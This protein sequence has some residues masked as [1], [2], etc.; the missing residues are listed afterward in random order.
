MPDAYTVYNTLTTRFGVAGRNRIEDAYQFN[1]ITTADLDEMR[2]WGMTCIRVP[3]WYLTV[4]ETNGAWRSDAFTHLDWIVNE[5]WKRGIYTI[6]DFHGLPGGDCPWAS[7]GEVQSSGQFF[8][9]YSDQVEGASIWYNIAAHFNGNP[10]IAAYDLLNEPN[11]SPNSGALWNIYNWY[12]YTMSGAP[13]PNHTIQLEG[14]WDWSTLPNPSSYGW[15]NVA[16][17][18]HAYAFGANG[19]YDP[20]TA[21]VDGAA[22]GAI[23][24]F[25]NYQSCNIPDYLE[26]SSP[27]NSD[28]NSFLYEHAVFNAYGVGWANWTWKAE[29]GVGDN[30]ADTVP[31]N[32]PSVPNSQKDGFDA[33]HPRRLHNH[34]DPRPLRSESVA[35][36]HDGRTLRGGGHLHLD[37]RSKLVCHRQLGCI[38]QR[39]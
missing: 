17:H 12:F 33:D 38:V 32:W 31:Y 6:L 11:S 25:L 10:G 35:P 23:S 28:T 29:G 4:V 2:S 19:T 8:N 5:A 37:R 14:N 22:W 36:K 30:W 7:C 16:Y 15:S 18:Q 27:S 20:T 39:R 3:F 9:V 13:D 34:R 21:Q 24:S 1:W 26:R